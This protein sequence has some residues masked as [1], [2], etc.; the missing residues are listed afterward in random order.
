MRL[1]TLTVFLCLSFA[2]CSFNRADF[3]T[4][5]DGRPR[6]DQMSDDG[7]TVSSVLHNLR[8]AA[9]LKF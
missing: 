2:G 8:P 3:V 7:K 6:Q 1:T 4:G 9:I 5:P